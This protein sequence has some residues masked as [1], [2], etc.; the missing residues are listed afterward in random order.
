MPRRKASLSGKTV[1]EKNIEKESKKRSR[2]GITAVSENA[3]SENA[4]TP[5]TPK[6]S[7]VSSDIS[8]VRKVLSL[9]EASPD[10]FFILCDGRIINGYLDLA[11]TLE[12]M[13]DTIFFYHVN[14]ERNDFATWICDVFADEALGNSLRLCKSRAD[15]LLALYKKLFYLC[16]DYCSAN[17]VDAGV[18]ESQV[19]SSDNIQNANIQQAANSIG[20]D[21]NQNITENNNQGDTR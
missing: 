21:L 8:H 4:A 11:V 5:R 1:L 18:R 13:D 15:M 9:P 17:T 3:A 19:N 10:K 20:H 12:N 2:K 6:R 14:A 7:H 16:H